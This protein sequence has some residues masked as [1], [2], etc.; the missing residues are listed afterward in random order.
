MNKG[1]LDMFHDEVVDSL[2]RVSCVEKLH[3]EMRN[4]VSGFGEQ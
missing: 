2:L 3:D 4:M 1:L